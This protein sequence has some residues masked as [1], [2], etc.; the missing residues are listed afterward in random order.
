MAPLSRSFSLPVSLSDRVSRLKVFSGA[1]GKDEVSLPPPTQESTLTSRSQVRAGRVP[2]ETVPE[3]QHPDTLCPSPNPTSIPHPASAVDTSFP[4]DDGASRTRGRA[5]FSSLPGRFR[6][7]K[8]ETESDALGDS[9]ADAIEPR[10]LTDSS[11]SPHDTQASNLILSALD[12]GRNPSPVPAT[13]AIPVPDTSKRTS[14]ALAALGLRAAGVTTPI[15]PPKSTEPIQPQ[16]TLQPSRPVGSSSSGPRLPRSPSPFFRARRSR[17]EARKRDRSPEVGALKKDSYESDGES[18]GGERNFKPQVSA[19]EDADESGTEAASDDEPETDL[20]DEEEED[21]AFDEETE[22]NTEA[23][24]VFYEGDAAGLGGTSEPVEDRAELDTFGEEIEQDPLGEGPNVVVP[25]QPLFPVTFNQPV[26]R[27]SLKSGL[28]LETSRPIF[29]RDRC[30]INLTHGDPDGA[31][32]QSGKRMRR[33]VVLSD[34]SEESQY[35]VEWGIGTVARDGDELFVISV[36][37]DEAKGEWVSTIRLTPVD[38]KSWSSA[39]K[40]AKLRIQKEVCEQGDA[41]DASAK[42]LRCSSSNRSRGSCNARG[43]TSL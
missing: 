35:A 15:S 5:M 10:L 22:K 6:R 34:L 32:E 7:K 25:P 36:K 21:L 18:V 9:K 38:P 11:L 42:L 4:E 2:L 33:Y 3:D 13:A 31:L 37:E 40:A 23:N 27:K 30:T 20:T 24:A 39:D 14:G 29:A 16:A 12:R 8:A 43:S 41:A 17:E 28:E 19:Y 26:R 1:A